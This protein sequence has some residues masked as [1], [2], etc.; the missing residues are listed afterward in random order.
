MDGIVSML[1]EFKG[2]NDPALVKD[3][4]CSLNLWVEALT[5]DSWQH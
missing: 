4:F 5:N 3:R 2:V 1:F